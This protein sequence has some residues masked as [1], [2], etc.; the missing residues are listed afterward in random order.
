MALDITY[1]NRVQEVSLI[2]CVTLQS[3]SIMLTIMAY[4]Q[5]VLKSIRVLDVHIVH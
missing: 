1:I 5:V 4:L 3:S 2:D